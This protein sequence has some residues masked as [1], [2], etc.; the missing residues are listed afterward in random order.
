MDVLGDM[1]QSDGEMVDGQG[2]RVDE[3]G[4]MVKLWVAKSPV[5]R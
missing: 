4:R 2:K 3:K 1:V 5:G